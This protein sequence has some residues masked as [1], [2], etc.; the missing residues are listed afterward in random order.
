[1]DRDS[2]R[3]PDTP[4]TLPESDRRA[5]PAG[6]D[7]S[8]SSCERM[9]SFHARA[10]LYSFRTAPIARVRDWRVFQNPRHGSAFARSRT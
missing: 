6:A 2:R 3:A 10:P 7:S 5:P 8:P 9:S 1:M 4:L